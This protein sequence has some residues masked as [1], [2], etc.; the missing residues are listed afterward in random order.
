MRKRLHGRRIIGV[1]NG[2]EVQRLSMLAMCHKPSID[3]CGYWQS[4]V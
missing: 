3:F 4:H 1:S 2:D